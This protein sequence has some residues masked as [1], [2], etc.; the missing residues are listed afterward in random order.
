MKYSYWEHKEWFTGNDFIIV[1]SGIV[2]LTC[3]INLKKRFPKSNV[4]VLEKGILPQGASTKNAGF[5]CF[6]S[7]SE[8]LSD[9]KNH[10]KEEVFSLVKKR[11]EG[12]LLLRK[13]LGDKKIDFQQ[14]YGYEIFINQE[15]LEESCGGVDELNQLLF[16]IFKQNIFS[17][18]QDRFKFQNCITTQ[19]VNLFEGQINTGKMVTELLNLA[20]Q[21]GI[22]ILNNTMV[23]SFSEDS[24][25]VKIQ[26]NQGEFRSSKLCFATNG[27][28]KELL[29][30]NIQPAR[31]QV[32]ITKP[33][34]DL[35]IKGTFH[36]DEGY[37]YFRNIHNRILFGGGRNLDFTTEETTQFGQTDLIQESL[38]G[39]LKTTILPGIKFE[40]DHRWSGIMGVGSQKTPIIKQLSNHVFCG[41]RLGGMGVAIG[42][43]VGKELAELAN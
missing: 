2:G 25:H 29:K 37:Y 6:G 3:A 11:W 13:L 31:A 41:V 10:S 35:H 17:I 18:V 39:L 40:I 32:L 24:N 19:I 5:A 8:L 33:I 7:A 15:K 36:L 9:L 28:S 1:G 21:R 14:N 20:Q 12:L 30:E 23:K 22:K 38:E 27:F 4:L 42:S 26:T 16:P 43:L 34:K